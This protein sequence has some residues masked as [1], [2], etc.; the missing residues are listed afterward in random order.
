LNHV[1]LAEKPEQ[2][3]SD[4]IPHELAHLILR[5]LHGKGPT[6]HGEEWQDVMRRL[7]VAP[8]RLHKLDTTNS[9][10]SPKVHGYVCS[11]NTNNWLSRLQHKRAQAGGVYSCRQCK[12]PMHFPIAST[13]AP[14]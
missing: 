13:L 1:L 10:A 6:S 12:G 8:D 11:C 9:R 2:F 14:E 3:E 5:H 4:V 7:G